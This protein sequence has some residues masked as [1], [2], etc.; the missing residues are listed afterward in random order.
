MSPKVR[1]AEPR[2]PP[3]AA[4]GRRPGPG[5]GLRV[6]GAPAGADA[7]G[8][9]VDEGSARCRGEAEV[10]IGSLERGW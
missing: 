6:E 1:R 8:G 9:R 7:A 10:V 4:A 5:A 3:A 2:G